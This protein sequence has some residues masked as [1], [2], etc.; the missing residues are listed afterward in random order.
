MSTK[1]GKLYGWFETGTE[2]VIWTVYEDGPPS[3]ERMHVLE[4][5]D[6]L[7][8]W[9]IFSGRQVF[10]GIIRFDTKIGSQALGQVALGLWVHGIQEGYDPD[11]WAR[12]FFRE[13]GATAL[14]AEVTPREKRGKVE[15]VKVSKPSPT[16]FRRKHGR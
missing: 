3:Y 1:T 8:I 2:G 11:D 13:P 4:N 12:L 15:K 6:R 5:G 9:E 7:R 10:N 14:K 16:K